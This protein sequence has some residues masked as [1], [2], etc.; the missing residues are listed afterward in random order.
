MYNEQEI[1]ADLGRG[2]TAAF[3]ILYMLY[4]PRIEIFVVKMV[5]DHQNAEDI[6]HNIF[7]KIWEN[8]ETISQV[9][10]FRKYLFKMA[11][12]A[13]FDLYVHNVIRARFK[14]AI[15]M[16]KNLQTHLYYQEEEIDA[17]D[18]ATLIDVAINEMPP[19]RRSVFQMSRHKGLS[20]KEIARELHISSKTVENHI[21]Q[22]LEDLR[23]RIS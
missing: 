21:A 12:N 7:L 10:S 17:R 5:K 6:T 13:V 3:D 8:R 4:A 14:K 9:N 18:L 11:K 22:A 2:D 23:K 15:E 16:K 19:K 1:L 20:H